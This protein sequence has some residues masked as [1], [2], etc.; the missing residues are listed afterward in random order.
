M[1]RIEIDIAKICPYLIA[2]QA[3][4]QNVA[5]DLRTGLESNDRCEV[6]ENFVDTEIISDLMLNSIKIDATVSCTGCKLYRKGFSK[7]VKAEV[8]S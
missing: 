7:L 6:G 1:A 3:P 8:K 4:V 2:Q 5:V